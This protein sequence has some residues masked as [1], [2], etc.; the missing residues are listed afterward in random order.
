MK[1]RALL[2][3]AATLTSASALAAS[4]FITVPTAALAQQA[5]EPIRIMQCVDPA[6][7]SAALRPDGQ[8]FI[9]NGTKI[10]TFINSQGKEYAFS[11]GSDFTS[12]PDGSVGY[13]TQQCHNDFGVAS[14]K[15]QLLARMQN[16]RLFDDA[17]TAPLPEMY[18][19]TSKVAGDN[20]C[21]TQ[22]KVSCSFHNDAVNS[23]YS[24]GNKILMQAFL[25]DKG[26]ILT[27][28]TSRNNKG[29]AGAV[30]M[31]TDAKSGAS[32]DVSSYQPLNY[33]QF[34]LSVGKTVPVAGTSVA[35]A[36]VAGM[37]NTQFQPTRP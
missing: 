18:V 17:L 7:L 5:P 4:G 25:P 13:I 2:E 35:M 34:A 28:G 31:I 15:V 19:T 30:I 3:K 12:R 29:E 14:G 27:V 26:Q 16:V 20:S 6:T 22:A 21:K 8:K 33:S 36:P 10:G 1:I 37:V 11:L 24:K 32:F 23:I 9:L